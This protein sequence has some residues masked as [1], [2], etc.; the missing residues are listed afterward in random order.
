MRITVLTGVVAAVVGDVVAAGAGAGAGV[1][2][3]VPQATI[4]AINET[5]NNKHTLITRI[6]FFL[7]IFPSIGDYNLDALV[8]I[9]CLTQPIIALYT[10]F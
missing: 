6:S 9:I 3:F 4:E 8:G 2:S 7:S 5:S 10:S 1:V